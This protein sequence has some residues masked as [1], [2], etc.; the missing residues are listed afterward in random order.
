LLVATRFPG[1]GR[2]RNDSNPCRRQRSV[3]T[4]PA[5]FS[6]AGAA[7]R[8]SSVS[9]WSSWGPARA[10][11]EPGGVAAR[12]PCRDLIAPPIRPGGAAHY[13]Y[14]LNE[15]PGPG[16]PRMSC[17]EAAIRLAQE[18]RREGL[19]LRAIGS[20]L[21]GVRERRG[22]TL[23]PR[24]GSPIALVTMGTTAIPAGRSLLPPLLRGTRRNRDEEEPQGPAGQR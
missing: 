14:A 5:L 21:G 9:L 1:T 13:P 16:L 8:P 11:R 18:L 15:A 19:S 10:S 17:E 6:S 22:G 24:R 12:G 20:R 7:S 4:L 2:T 3:P 23:M